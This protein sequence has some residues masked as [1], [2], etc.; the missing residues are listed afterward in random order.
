[1]LERVD[2]RLPRRLD[3][4][5]GNPGRAPLGR[6]VRGV[7]QDAGDRLG[8]LRAVED[9]D[10]EVDQLDVG[11]LRVDLDQRR[12]QRLVQGVDR[13]VALG[14]PDVALAVGPRRRPDLDR[15][16]GLD[17]SVGTLLYDRPP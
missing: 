17:V 9:P 15:R 8:P 14:G 6:A 7:E 10:L 12:A 3:H 5:L 2:Q 11:E 16:F 1:V 4:V 13:A